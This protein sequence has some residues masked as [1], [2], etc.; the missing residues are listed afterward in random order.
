MERG[1]KFKILR[2]KK[3]NSKDM[4]QTHQKVVILFLHTVGKTEFKIP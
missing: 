4:K 1:K 3:N 2:K